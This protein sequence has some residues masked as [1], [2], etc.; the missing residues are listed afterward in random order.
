MM[1][2]KDKQ[3]YNAIDKTLKILENNYRFSYGKKM[4]ITEAFDT[5]KDLYVLFKNFEKNTQKCGEMVIKR[6]I[7]LVDL[8]IKID[9]D[10][11]HYKIYDEILKYSYK[12]GASSPCARRCSPTRRV[13]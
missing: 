7:P 12:L 2:K 10:K 8:L 4:T 1:D 3:L 9:N 13:R 6:F 5:I 11:T